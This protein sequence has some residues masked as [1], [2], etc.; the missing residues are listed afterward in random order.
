MSRVLHVR[1]KPT[2]DRWWVLVLD[3]GHEVNIK[4]PTQI[5]AGRGKPT[6][7]IHPCWTCLAVSQ[8]RMAK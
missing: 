1:R 4:S 2:K 8:A 6:R 5:Q 7:K 3:C